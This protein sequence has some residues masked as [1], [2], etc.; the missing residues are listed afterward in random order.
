[1]QRVLLAAFFRG[2]GGGLALAATP[3]ILAFGAITLQAGVRGARGV[4][5]VG[6]DI[7]DCLRYF[8]ELRSH[9]RKRGQLKTNW[10]PEEDGFEV[11]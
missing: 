5:N 11:P 7:G 4:G 1:M 2:V 9:R 6:E 3:Y 10:V 8:N